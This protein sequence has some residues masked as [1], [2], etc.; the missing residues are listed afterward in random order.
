MMKSWRKIF[1][2]WCKWYKPTDPKSPTKSKHVT[3]KTT[4]GILQSNCL[5]QWEKFLKHRERRYIHAI[6]L[7]IY[8]TN[9]SSHVAHWFSVYFVFFLCSFQRISI[10]LSSSLLIFFSAVSNMLSIPPRIIA[11]FNSFVIFFIFTMSLFNL[12]NLFSSFRNIWK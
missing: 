1:Q 4:K 12:Y 10:S 6:D 3:K 2:I 5:S 7:H 11:V 9:Q 8:L